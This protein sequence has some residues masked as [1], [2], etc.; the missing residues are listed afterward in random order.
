MFVMPFMIFHG[1]IS[2]QGYVMSKVPVIVRDNRLRLMVK[3]SI[4]V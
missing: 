4:Y 1:S 2:T 3:E